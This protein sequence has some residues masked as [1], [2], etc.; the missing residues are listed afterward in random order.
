MRVLIFGAEGQLG[1]AIKSCLRAAEHE[2]LGPSHKEA[3][4]TD[5]RNLVQAVA[6]FKPDIT[7]NCAAVHDAKTCDEQPALAERVNVEAVRWMS[8]LADADKSRF[9]HISTDQVLVQKQGASTYADE[10]FP[11]FYYDTYSRTKR[12]GEKAVLECQTIFRVSGLYGHT[13]CRGKSRPNFVEQVVA[14]SKKKEV[15]HLPDNIGCSPGYCEDIGMLMTK[16]IRIEGLPHVIHLSP[17]NLS[18]RYS[19]FQFAWD[20]LE[21]YLDKG[22]LGPIGHIEPKTVQ[23]PQMKL[24]N[25]ITRFTWTLPAVRDSLRRY[26]EKR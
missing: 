25:M 21:T 10:T 14:A 15:L 8:A 4:I 3:D 22:P 13:P 26:F 7:I 23:N 12:D 19:W 24:V 18:G 20:I 1:M 2:V 6:T 17:Y 9:Y 11:P 16:L 5:Y